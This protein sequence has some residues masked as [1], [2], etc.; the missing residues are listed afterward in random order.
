MTAKTEALT[1]GT[2][3]VAIGF[4]DLGSLSAACGA[5]KLQKAAANTRSRQP[6]SQPLRWVGYE[7]SAYAV[8]KALV[9]LEM[10]KL[11]ASVDM[12]LQVRLINISTCRTASK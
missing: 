1:P 5:L 6:A 2:T 12:L 4:V 10:I 9:L 8:A 11:D 7:M 3:H